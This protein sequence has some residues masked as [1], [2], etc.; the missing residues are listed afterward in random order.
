MGLG[1]PPPRGPRG[2]AEHEPGEHDRDQR[3]RRHLPVPVEAGVQRPGGERRDAARA[4]RGG[5]ARAAAATPPNSSAQ[6]REA[7][8][9]ELGGVS[10]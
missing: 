8:E 4:A 2:L 7:D 9:A 10:R 1:I 5:R 3:Q 6:Q